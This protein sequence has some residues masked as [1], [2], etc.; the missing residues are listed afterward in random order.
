M[1]SALHVADNAA[2][3]ALCGLIFPQKTTP[4]TKNVQFGYRL[5]VVTF[6]FSG[7]VCMFCLLSGV[8]LTDEAIIP[9]GY[10]EGN[11]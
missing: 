7:Q 8:L 6:V 5:T 11:S 4:L 2:L 3:R 10:Y 9:Q 1:W